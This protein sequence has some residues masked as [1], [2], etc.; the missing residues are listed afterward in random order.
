MGHCE[1]EGEGEGEGAEQPSADS[2]RSTTTSGGLP[3]SLH[4]PRKSA[5]FVAVRPPSFPLFSRLPFSSTF[6]VF[7][8]HLSSRLRSCP[9]SSSSA[10]PRR[11]RAESQPVE[12]HRVETSESERGVEGAVR[13]VREYLCH[14]VRLFPFI[15]FT[16]VV[17]FLH[18]RL[19]SPFSS[20][21][22]KRTRR[23][24]GEA[25]VGLCLCLLVVGRASR[26]RCCSR[27]EGDSVEREEKRKTKLVLRPSLSA[28]ATLLG[29]T[30]AQ[31]RAF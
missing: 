21:E 24:R 20:R 2:E 29:R 4:T 1:E 27:S 3:V 18:R 10:L 11:S 25:C 15:M 31:S 9:L 8:R 7:L 23:E 6:P 14:L 30:G 12:P 22:K 5:S 16:L 13:K 17:F 28:K 26:G 19:F